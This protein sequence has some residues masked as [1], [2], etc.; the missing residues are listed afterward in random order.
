MDG[1]YLDG[2]EWMDKELD[3]YE[4]MNRELDGYE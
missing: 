2:Y 1:W 3:G 4:W